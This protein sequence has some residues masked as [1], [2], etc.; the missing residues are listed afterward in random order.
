MQ[1]D[2]HQQAHAPWLP[3]S[4][5]WGT[6]GSASLFFG[7]MNR[8]YARLPLF[9]GYDP[10]MVLRPDHVKPYCIYGVDGS[11][12]G[13]R[14]GTCWGVE[15]WDCVP[16]CGALAT[17]HCTPPAAGQPWNADPIAGQV[18]GFFAFGGWRAGVQATRLEDAGPLLEYYAGRGV[19]HMY[20]E[21]V[22]E[23][24]T[25][26]AVESFF[27]VECEPDEPNVPRTT[28]HDPDFSTSCAEA[29]ARGRHIHAQYLAAHPHLSAESF[30]LLMLRR[31]HWS[32]PFVLAA[33]HMMPAVV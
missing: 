15:R 7:G 21:V 32:E 33:G 17:D 23:H 10:G 18:C 11:S 22:V 8:S 28:N 13:S 2:D 30:P 29:H 26:A 24:W 14:R 16:G 9:A 20:N 27:V 25:D 4:D 31:Q 6:R 3:I 19:Y 1:L 5:E 12:D